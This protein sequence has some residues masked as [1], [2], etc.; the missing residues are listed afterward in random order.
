MS[1]ELLPG[2]E[3]TSSSQCESSMCTGEKDKQKY[4]HGRK[5]GQHCAKHEDCRQNTYCG[6]LAVWPY[7]STCLPYKEMGAVCEVDHEC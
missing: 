3:C 2:R 5:S 4:C 7:S 6:G 1:Q